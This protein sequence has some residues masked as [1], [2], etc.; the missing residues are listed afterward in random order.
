MSATKLPKVRTVGRGLGISC[1]RGGAGGRC[2]SRAYSTDLR[3]GFFAISG[4]VMAAAAANA[5]IFL[6]HFQA[7]LRPF[8]AMCRRGIA[9]DL[10]APGAWRPQAVPCPWPA[11]GG[12]LRRRSSA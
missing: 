4:P 9:L 7:E 10:K 1:C 3:V 12:R 8:V 11:R 5:L 2:W 6:R